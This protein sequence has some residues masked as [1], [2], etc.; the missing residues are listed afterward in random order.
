MTD[1]EA[2]LAKSALEAARITCVV[3][4]DD[5]GGLRPALTFTQGIQL[6]VPSAEAKRAKQVLAK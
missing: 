2:N 3:H 1:A 5:C 4:R 6:L